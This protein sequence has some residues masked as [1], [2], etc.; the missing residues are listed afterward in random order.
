[1]SDPS[2]MK[3]RVKIMERKRAQQVSR[4]EAQCVWTVEVEDSKEKAEG[5]QAE[6][7][8]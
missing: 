8:S 3:V 2:R 7:R 5:S 6:A 1:M 4:E